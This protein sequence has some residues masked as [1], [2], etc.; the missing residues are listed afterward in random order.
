[1]QSHIFVCGR[2]GWVLS[3]LEGVTSVEFIE[4]M[5]NYMIYPSLLYLPK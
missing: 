5:I 4:R 2:F 3:E 1:M